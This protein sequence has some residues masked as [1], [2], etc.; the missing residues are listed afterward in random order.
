MRC[1]YCGREPDFAD[2]GNTV[3]GDNDDDDVLYCMYAIVQ[4]QQQL[5]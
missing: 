2:D 3:Y 1:D 5:L 4:Y